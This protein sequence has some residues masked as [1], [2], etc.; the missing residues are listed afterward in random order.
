MRR[1]EAT[2]YDSFGGMHGADLH[3]ENRV[4]I[5]F[6]HYVAVWEDDSTK[7]QRKG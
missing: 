3:K 1:H 4:A 5:V 6:G 7:I 2:G